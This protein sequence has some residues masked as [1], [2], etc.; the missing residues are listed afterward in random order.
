MESLA[1]LEHLEVFLKRPLVKLI[2]AVHIGK[3]AELP[4]YG[5]KLPT[6]ADAVKEAV[7][8]FLLF[9]VPANESFVHKVIES[10]PV[11]IKITQLFVVVDHDG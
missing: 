7:K 9:I 3:G 8:R 2:Y 6:T 4:K 5:R 1:G 11:T 10:N